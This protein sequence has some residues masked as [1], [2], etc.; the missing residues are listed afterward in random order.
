MCGI[1]HELD[2]SVT[3]EVVARSAKTPTALAQSLIDDA[4]A[5]HSR[6]EELFARFTTLVSHTTSARLAE[7]HGVTPRV[8][9]ALERRCTQESQQLDALLP[10]AQR[11]S[12]KL[13]KEHLVAVSTALPNIARLMRSA[14][15]SEEA[16]LNSSSQLLAHTSL[17]AT[18]GRGFSI[19][20]SSS[21]VVVVDPAAVNP[22][23]VLV[24]TTKNGT[25][26]SEVLQENEGGLQHGTSG[27]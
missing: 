18:L 25:V 17:E 22:G 27:S 23:E 21:G 10:R 19:T 7:L 8:R 26:T 6:T 14:V 12:S 1:G 13:I 16:F 2:R 4:A 5:L 20:R 11:V 9:Q 15:K 3:D 24:T